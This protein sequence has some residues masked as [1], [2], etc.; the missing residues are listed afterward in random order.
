[1]QSSQELL[2]TIYLYKSLGDKQ[3]VLWEIRKTE[4]G[5]AVLSLLFYACR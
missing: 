2:K 1:M 3:S 5:Q 4:N